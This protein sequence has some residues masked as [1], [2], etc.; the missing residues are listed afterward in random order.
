[1]KLD[2][3]RAKVCR[4]RYKDIIGEAGDGLVSVETPVDGRKN[5]LNVLLVD[6]ELD[7]E[8]G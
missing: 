2:R 1:M 6:S 4:N 8:A 5:G 3:L 7:N